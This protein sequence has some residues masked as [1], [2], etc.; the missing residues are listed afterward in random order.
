MDLGYKLA[1]TILEEDLCELRILQM[2]D[3]LQNYFDK[4]ILKMEKLIENKK[5]INQDKY[6][7]FKRAR[8]CIYNDM[9]RFR[10][11]A[12][13][14]E[15]MESE[16]EENKCDEEKKEENKEV[17]E[18]DSDSSSISSEDEI[19]FWVPDLAD[20]DIKRYYCL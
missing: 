18:I 1:N 6:T 5:E 7:K 3:F 20:A 16:A 9:I 8:D 11:M 12:E 2:M 19:Y 15:Q 14:I 17:L 4:R 10:S 13:K